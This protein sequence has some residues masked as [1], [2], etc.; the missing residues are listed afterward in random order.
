M[1]VVTGARGRVDVER[2]R[3]EGYL[4]VEDVL[5]VERVLPSGALA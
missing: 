1:A 2:F 3:E 4:V 5:D